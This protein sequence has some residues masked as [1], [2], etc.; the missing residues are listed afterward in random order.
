MYIRRFSTLSHAY[1]GDFSRL[2]PPSW[3]PLGGEGR[4]FA[5]VPSPLT[6][7][8]AD[9]TVTLEFRG[10][11][12]TVRGRGSNNG[13]EPYRVALEEACSAALS[14]DTLMLGLGDHEMN[15]VNRYVERKNMDGMPPNKGRE[16]KDV[17][18]VL[19]YYKHYI[20]VARSS[21]ALGINSTGI[22]RSKSSEAASFG[23][24]ASRNRV[25]VLRLLSLYLRKG[26]V[27]KD[28][29]VLEEFK[30]VAPSIYSAVVSE[31]AL[32][33]FCRLHEY[34]YNIETNPL[35]K[36]K[37]LKF[38][39]AVDEWILAELA[40]L[41]HTKLPKLTSEKSPPMIDIL[42][43]IDNRSRKG[44]SRFLI[45]F[46]IMPMFAIVFTISYQLRLFMAGGKAQGRTPSTMLGDKG[47]GYFG[48][49]TSQVM[50]DESRD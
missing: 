29:D 37:N 24:A 26:N 3:R 36:R 17:K 44:W 10:I 43:A 45:E 11:P 25:E 12:Y 16:L 23:E 4:H 40:S 50:D 7:A 8:F 15:T 5:T 13:H 2:T 34:I 33:S 49:N 18:H 27:L 21:A 38:L 42:T 47:Y 46:V 32:Y 39:V 48:G 35:L 28:R 9:R 30:L 14:C 31:G 1:I 19:K 41:A 20:E 6:F 22:G